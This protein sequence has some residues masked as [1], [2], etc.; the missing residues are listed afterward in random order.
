M[1]ELAP[2]ACSVELSGVGNTTGVALVEIC[3]LP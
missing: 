3:E 1:A 2:G